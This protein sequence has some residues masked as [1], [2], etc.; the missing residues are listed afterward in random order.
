MVRECPVKAF[1]WVRF[2][3]VTPM[4][5]LFC[6]SKKGLFELQQ[7]TYK[8]FYP[9]F[10]NKILNHFGYYLSCLDKHSP[11]VWSSLRCGYCL[12]VKKLYKRNS[13]VT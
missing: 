4:K 9:R 10:I 2:P 8:L 5:S 11:D 7:I 12:K 13:P 1:T 3:L 6:N